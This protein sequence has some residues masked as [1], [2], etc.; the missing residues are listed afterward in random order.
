MPTGTELTEEEKAELADIIE[1]QLGCGTPVKID[2]YPLVGKSSGSLRSLFDR[3]LDDSVSNTEGD[4]FGCS[5]DLM[6]LDQFSSGFWDRFSAHMKDLAERNVHTWI[7]INTWC[8]RSRNVFVKVFRS[9]ESGDYL[10]IPQDPG[11]D[12]FALLFRTDKVRMKATKP[13]VEREDRR[14]LLAELSRKQRNQLTL[15]GSFVEVGKSGVHYLIRRD[16][17][18]V[19]YRTWKIRG[20]KRE[21]LWFLATLCLHEVGYYDETFA[22]C[23]SPSAEMRAHLLYIRASEHYYWR[24]ANQHGI[25]DVLGGL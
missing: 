1:G 15:T 13:K 10:Y 3:N 24:K 16:R 20:S 2:H 22:G 19:A 17:P 11:L 23:K 21:A 4:A 14:E 12:R 8:F 9:P 25:N 18:A 5:P 7:H 6:P